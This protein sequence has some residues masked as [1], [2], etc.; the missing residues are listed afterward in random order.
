MTKIT[1]EQPNRSI[2]RTFFIVLIVIHI[3]VL[4]IIPVSAIKWGVQETYDNFNDND[5][6]WSLWVN[7]TIGGTITETGN[8]LVVKREAG[9]A[10]STSMSFE[11]I[12]L[13]NLEG[14]ENITM[15]GEVSCSSPYPSGPGAW[16][17]IYFGTDFELL[18]AYADEYSDGTNQSIITLKR[19]STNNNY[20]NRYLDGVYQNIFVPNGNH[21]W[22]GV[23]SD[24]NPGS[25]GQAKSDYIYYTTNNQT[26]NI[27]L[28]TVNNFQNYYPENTTFNISTNTSINNLVNI[29]LYLDGSLN[30]TKTITGMFNETIFSK[31]LSSLILGAHTWYVNVCET[32]NCKHSDTRTFD[33]HNLIVTYNS[34]TQE[35]N[36]ET[37]ELNISLDNDVYISSNAKFIYNGTTYNTIKTVN[38]NKINFVSEI[39][40][41]TNTDTTS[42][43]K[44]FYWTLTVGTA[45]QTI[46]Y[47]TTTYDQTINSINLGIC[48]TN[49]NITTLNFTA[50][51]AETRNKISNFDISMSLSYYIGDSTLRKVFSMTNLTTNETILCI[52]N[53]INYNI[54]GVI[55]YSKSSDGYVSRDY[56]FDTFNTNN[57]TQNVDLFLLN[58]SDSTSFIIKLR[59]STLLPLPDY[60]IEIQRYYPGS[61]EYEIVQVIK[62]DSNGQ[63]VG[64]FKT[65]TVD[66]RFI[67]KKDGITY[68]TTTKQKIVPESS[69]YTIQLTLEDALGSAWSSLAD[70]TGLTYTSSFNKNTNVFSINYVDNN[71]NFTNGNLLIY[72]T[73]YDGSD[74]LVCDTTS[75]SS[76]SVLSCDLTGNETGSYYGIFYLTRGSTTSF[77]DSK[78]F[79]IQTISDVVGMIGLLM[80]FFIILISASMFF[81]NEIA[82]IWAVNASII[83]LNFIGII[84]FGGVFIT[85]MLALSI[86]I[87]VTLRR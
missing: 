63:S 51:D 25:T 58:S 44:S 54:D 6:N 82:G 14:I 69:P 70:P 31:N 11:S 9:D 26:M 39:E 46:Q 7:G 71:D 72:K 32:D 80:G 18:Y 52:D 48:T 85:A 41:P 28:N 43:N 66:Y 35:T 53:N 22:F 38:G 76:T 29:S 57:V 75:T 13:P 24:N 4:C 50:W 47:N 77:I 17:G 10:G 61:N 2:L 5:I 20:F 73:S 65:E 84:S 59:D 8:E 3:G 86:I 37:F 21:I 49:T 74:N 27:T 56:Y 87:T 34:L 62:T 36:L 1:K 12:N 78:Q 55:S 16:S 81:F 83:M 30:E 45:L 67:V 15:E 19:N 60:L 42:E 23:Y 40:I 64:F 68:L 33:S 79:E